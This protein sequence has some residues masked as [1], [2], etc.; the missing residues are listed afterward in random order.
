MEKSETGRMKGKLLMK[1]ESDISKINLFKSIFKGREDVFAVR[2]EKGKKSGYMP[3]YHYDPYRYKTHKI[4]GGTFQDFTEKTYLQLSDEQILKHL[5]GNQL[6]GIY[7]LLQDNTSS[8]IVADFDKNKWEQECRDFI[9]VCSKNKIS[10]YLERQESLPESSEPSQK[11]P[12]N[13]RDLLVAKL[14]YRGLE[15]LE[16]AEY[17]FPNETKMIIQKLFE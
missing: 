7:P 17:Q 10:A 8:F 11:P 3:A 9:S 4:N 6:I 2:W 15:V 5:E 12:E 16:N 14:G 1:S 13:P